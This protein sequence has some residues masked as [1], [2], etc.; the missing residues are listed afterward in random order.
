MSPLHDVAERTRLALTAAGIGTFVWDLAED[1]AEADLIVRSH[2]RLDADSRFHPLHSTAHM[3]EDDRQRYLDA[4][5]RAADPVDGAAIEEDVR[6]VGPDSHLRWLRV[7]AHTWWD[8]SPS[9]PRWCTGIAADVTAGRQHTDDLARAVIAKD[10]FF[11]QVAHELRNP[12]A[13]LR[14]AL[15]LIRFSGDSGHAVERVRT[16]MERQVAQLGHLIDDLVEV[17]RANAGTLRLRRVATPLDESLRAAVEAHQP[18]LRAK[19]T[20]VVFDLPRNAV[21]L[22]A[23]PPRLVHALSG[24]VSDTTQTIA[25]AGTLCVGAVVVGAPPA[26]VIRITGGHAV[27]FSE[28]VGVGF[29]AARLLIELHG[30]TVEVHPHAPEHPGGFTVRLPVI[31][32][33]ILTDGG[34]AHPQER[35]SLG[36]KVLIID[37]NED[38]AHALAMLVW[39]LGGDAR[40]AFSS[41]A[42][43]ALLQAFTPDVVLLDIGLGD[44]DGYQTCQQLRSRLGDRVKIVAVTG[45]GLDRDKAR[46]QQAGF[47]GHLTKPADHGALARLL[48]LQ[49]PPAEGDGQA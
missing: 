10:D 13:P 6:I 48:S 28:P 8:G 4:M 3:H 18:A 12:L 49:A 43:L 41:A 9:R 25:A 40:V 36:R 23:D 16:M 47:N 7:T 26:V 45:F 44:L 33:D 21:T 20:R 38:A 5:S 27:S 32:D 29:M 14:T 31:P 39:E 19:G 46:A 17:S 22:D 2:F 1:R 11:S 35:R 30:G 42:G 24:L 34:S 15:D 37:D